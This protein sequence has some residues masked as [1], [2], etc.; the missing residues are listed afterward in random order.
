METEP[1]RFACIT[2]LLVSCSVS[3]LHVNEA[4]QAEQLIRLTESKRSTWSDQPDPWLDLDAADSAS[5]AVYVGPQNGLRDADKITAL[6]G[7]PGGVD[8]DQYA[9]HVTV[10]PKKGRA[11]FY[12]FVE[13]PHRSSSKPLV[14]WLNGGDLHAL[15]LDFG[16]PTASFS[17]DDLDHVCV[18]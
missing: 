13:S 2:L 9:G 4:N 17:L 11:L 15:P 16:P 12:Y 3:L 18:L 1:L 6:P 8:F 14:L 10:D 5:S 7:Q